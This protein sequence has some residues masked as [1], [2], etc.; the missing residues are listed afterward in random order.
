MVTDTA[1]DIIKEL[2]AD[3]WAK[4]SIARELDVTDVT[5]YRWEAGTTTP[6][7]FA[8]AALAKLKRMKPRGRNRPGKGTKA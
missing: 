3:G 1:T 2:V 5:V 8:L 7:H 4:A 6:D